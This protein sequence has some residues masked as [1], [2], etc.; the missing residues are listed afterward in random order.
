MDLMS[1]S[2]EAF[3]ELG[4]EEGMLLQLLNIYQALN[5][6]TVMANFNIKLRRGRDNL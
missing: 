2:I 3:G 6:K 5:L 4:C 1:L